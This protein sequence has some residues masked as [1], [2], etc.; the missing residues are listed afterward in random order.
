MHAM[1]PKAK[2]MLQ[3]GKK[4]LRDRVDSSWEAATFPSR[5]FRQSHKTDG[6]VD[7]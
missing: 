5:S 7:S 1:Y 3:T 6:R 2:S 4:N